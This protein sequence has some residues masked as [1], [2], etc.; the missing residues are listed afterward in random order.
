[1]RLATGIAARARALVDV[2]GTG[3]R[4]DLGR[5]RHREHLRSEREL[6][7]L[8]LVIPT[9][10]QGLAMP[11]VL[12]GEIVDREGRAAAAMRDVAIDWGSEI[13]GS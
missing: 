2:A 7:G 11:L 13:C 6:T 10:D 12:R 4:A 1:V 3:R 9:P 8:M 5:L